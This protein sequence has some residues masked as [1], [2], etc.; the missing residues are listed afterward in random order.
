MALKT[1]CFT[2]ELAI[3]L[4][5]SESDSIV[6]GECSE[7]RQKQRVDESSSSVRTTLRINSFEK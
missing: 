1:A 7:L 4:G 2:V 6:A 5:E 3:F